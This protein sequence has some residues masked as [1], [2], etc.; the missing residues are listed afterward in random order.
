MFYFKWDERRYTG[1]GCLNSIAG[2]ADLPD[3]IYYSQFTNCANALYASGEALYD[4]LAKFPGVR[5]NLNIELGKESLK[6]R[7]PTVH[8]QENDPMA[9]IAHWECLI[10]RFMGENSQRGYSGSIYL[11]L[12]AMGHRPYMAMMIGLMFAGGSLNCSGFGDQSPWNSSHEY[13]QFDKLMVRFGGLGGVW[14]ARY[15]QPLSSSVNYWYD[16]STGLLSSPD[17]VQVTKSIRQI[18]VVPDDIYVIS[19]LKLADVK[20]LSSIAKE[21]A[22]M[23]RIIQE[24]LVVHY[25]DF[26]PMFVGESE[27]K[28]D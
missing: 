20:K 4:D 17:W 27:G 14:P 3:M 28:A 10:P 8:F 2:R 16:Q 22:T 5:E 6:K 1:G 23:D 11:Q 19:K 24:T 18:H 12:L 9:E 25:P 21:L 26:V 13:M 15:T 7:Q